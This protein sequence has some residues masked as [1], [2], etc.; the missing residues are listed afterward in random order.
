VTEA[1]HGLQAV[2]RALQTAGAK[3]IRVE[4]GPV[5][6]ADDTPIIWS[7]DG[8]TTMPSAGAGGASE[9]KLAE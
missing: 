1:M 6:D 2:T 8:S 4:V 3:G 7:D 5:G 9:S